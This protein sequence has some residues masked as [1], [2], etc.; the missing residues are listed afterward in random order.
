MCAQVRSKG[1]LSL[2]S[3]K[4]V[5]ECAAS[6]TCKYDPNTVNA[7]SYS[8]AFDIYD[9]RTETVWRIK[10]NRCRS[11]CKGMDGHTNTDDALLK[12]SNK[13]ARQETIANTYTEQPPHYSCRMGTWGK[14]TSK[15]Q[16]QMSMYATCIIRVTTEFFTSPAQNQLSHTDD[17]NYSN[18][19]KHNTIKISQVR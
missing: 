18:C 6:N 12:S 4:S 16:R 2:P 1:A 10:M 8:G 14:R 19:F 13:R 15:K 9:C 11:D 5:S 7:P 17:E 3:A